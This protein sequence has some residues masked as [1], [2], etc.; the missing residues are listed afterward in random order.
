[1]LVTWPHPGRGD[2]PEGAPPT[3]VVD[4]P[5]ADSDREH[6][7]FRPLTRPALPNLGP[8]SWVR[9][10]ID[11][12]V[13]ARLQAAGQ[14]PQAAADR[15]TLARRLSYG[16]T[17]LP[18]APEVR[19]AFVRNRAPDAYE[20]LVDDLL[21]S[22]RLG[23][24]WAQFWL[25]LAR[26]AETD[27][28]EHDKVRSHAW[29][30]RDWV[31]RAA[32]QNLPYNTFVRWQIAGDLL[33]PERAEAQ[34]AT[35]FCVA[36]PDM[37]DVN[38]QEERRHYLLNEMT[39]TVGAVFL[40]LQMGCAQ[41]H[42]HKFD[43]ISQGDFYRLRAFFEAAVRVERDKSVATLQDQGSGESHF[44]IRG[45]WRRPGPKVT[46]AFPRI[47]DADSATGGTEP[48]SRRDLA[49]W[50]VEDGNPLVAR[51]MAN[52]VWQF[53][54]GRGLCE[55]PSDFGYAGDEPTHLELL[56]WLACELRDSGWDLKRLH[57]SIVTSATYQLA[58]RPEGEAE[59]AAWHK[60]AAY[61]PG[62]R[63]WGRFSRRRLEGE[64]VR[65]ALLSAAGVLN[66]AQGGPGVRPPLEEALR[67]T[68]LKGQWEVSPH[69]ADHYRRSIYVF[70]RRNLRFPI[71]EVLDRPDANASC[72]QRGRSTTAPQSLYLLNSPF[73]HLMAQK[74]A[75]RIRGEGATIPEAVQRAFHYTLSRP[76]TD[77]ELR[78]SLDFLA[79]AQATTEGF[80]LFCLALFNTSEFLYV[81]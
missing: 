17:G 42:D 20:R 10:P 75:A 21:A 49:Q 66:E 35:A 26:Y 70:A 69:E 9:Q 45:D 58:S 61:D 25:D 18:P 51:V 68:L 31:V 76:P 64:A 71:F 14:V 78:E 2:E 79:Q 22:H 7:A 57:R 65:D 16:L 27:G 41:C 23:A 29:Q 72:P 60:L 36:G 39:S 54:F 46:A 55:T 13:L 28:F 34:I 77:D 80:E 52:R 50:L 6:W 32:D 37:P 24:H 12:F 5:I 59:E 62:N 43:P 74:L 56:D 33:E 38:R 73:S 40:G 53:H 11:A 8:Q 1:M 4:P 48:L 15:A 3:E 67:D 30:Y 47:A 19:D 81:D 63:L 44:W